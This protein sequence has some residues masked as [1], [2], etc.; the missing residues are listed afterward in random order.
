MLQLVITV[1]VS[2]ILQYQSKYFMPFCFWLLK[3]L[4]T[5]C[6]IAWSSMKNTAWTHKNGQSQ[7]SYLAVSVVVV[8]FSTSLQFQ[9]LPFSRSSAM[10]WVRELKIQ[11][12]LRLRT[13]SFRAILVL[14]V[15][16]VLILMVLKARFHCNLCYSWFLKTS[17]FSDIVFG[18]IVVVGGYFFN[19]YLILTFTEMTIMKVIYI[20][21]FSRIAAVNEYFISRMLIFFNFV[22][23]MIIAIIRL[24]LKEYETNPSLCYYRD[25]IPLYQLKVRRDEH[26]DLVK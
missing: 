2:S 17:L 4:E 13:F 3:R 20:F 21:K 22:V 12:N 14:K 9:S 5:F 26:E 11:S 19:F 24:I 1:Y 6:C 18:L 25:Q 7:I 10:H 16:N 23:V 15:K 8:Y